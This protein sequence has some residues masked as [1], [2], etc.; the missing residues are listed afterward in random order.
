MQPD[1]HNNS[2]LLKDFRKLAR[3]LTIV[4]ND[5]PGSE[6]LLRGL[7]SNNTPVIGITGP[8]GAGK[9]TLVNAIINQLSA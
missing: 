8:P 4:E 5:L 6:D 3:E 9:S 1:K 7:K 2:I